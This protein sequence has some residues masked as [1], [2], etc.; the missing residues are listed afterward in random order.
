VS[1]QTDQTQAA[2]ALRLYRRM[3]RLHWPR[4]YAARILLIALVM[5]APLLLIIGFLAMQP[6]GS[7][8][9]R[10]ELLVAV[11]AALAGMAAAAWA[12]RAML[13]PV[14][15]ARRALGT[16]LEDGDLRPLPTDFTDD[17]G[18]LM[19]DLTYAIGR[20]EA[21]GS[22]LQE[23]PAFDPLTGLLN[24]P[25]ALDRL[26]QTFSL[27]WRE[28]QTVSLA[29]LDVDQLSHVNE[30][31][32]QST[33]DRVLVA[34][35]DRL[36]A[37]TRG[38]DWAARWGGDEFLVLIYTDLAGASIVL[39]RMR[40]AVEEMQLLAGGARVACTIS[41]GGTAVRSGEEPLTTLHRAEVAVYRAKNAGYNCVRLY[42]PTDDVTEP[43]VR[44]RDEA[45]AE[46][47]L[48]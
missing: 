19:R 44:P 8:L 20:W 6:D 11:L 17:A 34:I 38:G 33:G 5:Q 23:R 47:D 16:Y 4:G 15:L 40:A 13:E 27:A 32:G 35:G 36:Q 31:Y 30:R 41:A 14:L 7:P 24:R 37:A 26:H 3:A 28:G 48:G 21:Q 10:W 39:E 1:T 42:G 12:I 46:Q 22:R 29:L 2:E 18:L 9:Y 45:D 43:P 25:A